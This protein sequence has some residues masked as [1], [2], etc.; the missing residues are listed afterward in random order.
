[1]LDPFRLKRQ[2]IGKLFSDEADRTLDGDAAFFVDSYLFKTNIQ[3][4]S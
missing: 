4:D 2:T 3:K 1:M